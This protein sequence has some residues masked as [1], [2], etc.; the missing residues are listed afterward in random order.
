MIDRQGGNDD[1]EN[2][3]HQDIGKDKAN[4]RAYPKG[5]DTRKD[6]A[7]ESTRSRIEARESAKVWANVGRR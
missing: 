3:G 7:E 5:D 2:G 4:R 1:T 6:S